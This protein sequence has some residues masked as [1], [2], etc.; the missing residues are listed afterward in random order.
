MN[1]RAT[2]LGTETCDQDR[3]LLRL[4]GNNTVRLHG[5]H[6]GFDQFCNLD[7][8]SDFAVIFL[9]RPA[10]L[11]EMREELCAYLKKPTSYVYVGI[12]RYQIKGNDIGN[13]NINLLDNNSEQILAWVNKFLTD[14]GFSYKHKGHME[15]DRGRFFNAVQ[16][17]TWIYAEQSAN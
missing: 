12:N 6:Q 10:W 2:Q 17:L 5:N 4:I 16:P 14:L 13:L 8:D 1:W 11:S 3:V 15:K 7:P 9:N